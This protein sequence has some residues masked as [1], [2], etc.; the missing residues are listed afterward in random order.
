MTYECK[1]EKVLPM[2]VHWLHISVNQKE[3]GTIGM[4]QTC[5]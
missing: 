4:I 3:D 1:L 2:K 5:S